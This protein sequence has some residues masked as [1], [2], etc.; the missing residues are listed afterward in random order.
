MDFDRFSVLLLTSW[1]I[2][3]GW[4]LPGDCGVLCTMSRWC[5]LLVFSR[6]SFALFF[7]DSLAFVRS[8][9]C[10]FWLTLL[11]RCSAF[12]SVFAETASVC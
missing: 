12:D 7:L 2:A 1:S 8:L 10:V 11:T 5:L 3:A 6:F 4:G 9:P